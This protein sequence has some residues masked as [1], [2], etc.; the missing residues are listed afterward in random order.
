MFSNEGENIVSIYSRHD[1]KN[2]NSN[3]N[4]NTKN[5]SPDNPTNINNT[6][7]NISAQKPKYFKL[8]IILITVGSALV[9]TG[10]IVP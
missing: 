8:I 10:V 6:Q 9:A 3:L 5:N 4:F 7:G 1:N 2:K